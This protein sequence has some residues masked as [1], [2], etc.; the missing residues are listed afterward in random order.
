MQIVITF[1][2][3]RML[4]AVSEKKLCNNIR[5]RVNIY[6]TCSKAYTLMKRRVMSGGHG[7]DADDRLGYGFMVFSGKVVLSEK[8]RK[9]A[10]F[11][12]S[13]KSLYLVLSFKIKNKVGFCVEKREVLRQYAECLKSIICSSIDQK[14]V[15]NDVFMSEN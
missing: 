7:R 13:I 15:L 1:S 2:E 6:G 4:A 5:M 8:W 10:D 12:R 14:V 11:G 9:L 3:N